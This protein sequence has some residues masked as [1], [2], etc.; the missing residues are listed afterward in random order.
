MVVV[1]V[2]LLLL[3][4][5]LVL[6]VLLILLV[7]V[8]VV[9]VLLLLVL[10]LLVGCS[11]WGPG[12]RRA[13]PTMMSMVKIR[14]IAE[15]A[16]SSPPA[17]PDPVESSLESIGRSEGVS[18]LPSRGSIQTLV[19]IDSVFEMHQLVQVWSKSEKLWL[20]ATVLELSLIHI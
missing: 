10:L 4:L 20:P 5:L 8:L 13:V 17:T 3:L 19:P 18:A 7:V 11:P 1:V 9:L 2:V 14:Q 15:L 6:L 16:R 12:E